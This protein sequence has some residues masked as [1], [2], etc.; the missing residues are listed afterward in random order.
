MSGTE[1][2]EPPRN[3]ALGE[4][5]QKLRSAQEGDPRP[6]PWRGCPV[7][8]SAHGVHESTLKVPS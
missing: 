3:A 6:E 2:L 7:G 5:L 1:L 8:S 4:E